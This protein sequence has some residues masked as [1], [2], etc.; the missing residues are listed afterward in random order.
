MV[1]VFGNANDRARII[2]T[3]VAQY[4]QLIDCLERSAKPSWFPDSLV[5]AKMSIK[6]LLNMDPSDE[7]WSKMWES[8]WNSNWSLDEKPPAFIVNQQVRHGIAAVLSLA[9]IE[10]E[11]R[12]LAR[13]ELNARTWIVQSLDSLIQIMDNIHHMSHKS[14]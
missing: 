13:E 2:S 10:E 8:L 12:R 14:H 1:S 9:R 11:K 3:H 5:H 6:E 4:N 7:R